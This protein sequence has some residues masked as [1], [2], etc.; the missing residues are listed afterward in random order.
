MLSHTRHFNRHLE[1]GRFNL[2]AAPQCEPVDLEEAKKFII[3]DHNNHDLIIDR[4][5]VAARQ[6][7][8]QLTKITFIT[9]E[10]QLFFDHFPHRHGHSGHGHWA[11]DNFDHSGVGHV[12]T[13][14]GHAEDFELD[15]PPLQSIT[16]VKTF[17]DDDVGTIFDAANYHVR[18]YKGIDVVKGRIALRNASTWPFGTRSIDAVEIQ[19][20]AGYGNSPEDVPHEIRQAILEEV[21]FKYN[22]RG[23]C[24][25]DKIGSKTA[26]GL[27]QQFR[28]MEL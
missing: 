13:I 17:N 20:K 12:A 24:P 9:Q 11:H 16:H 25:T 4:L 8:E 19:F 27:L 1:S 22:N 3:V 28:I 21:T 2:I 10:W 14:L 7:A 15:K 6:M 5:I 23:D 26:R 18:T